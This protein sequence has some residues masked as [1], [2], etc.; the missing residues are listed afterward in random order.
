ML[1]G[2][3]GDEDNFFS[4]STKELIFLEVPGTNCHF[5]LI[6]L[7]QER[8]FIWPT[9][10]YF[11]HPS[12]IIMLT[13]VHFHPF[14]MIMLTGQ[15][16]EQAWLESSDMLFFSCPLCSF[17]RL[18]GVF[19]RSRVTFVTSSEWESIFWIFL[20]STTTSWII[21]WNISN[22]LPGKLAIH[23]DTHPHGPADILF[24][25]FMECIHGYLGCSPPVLEYY[26]ILFRND[27]NYL[28]C[29]PAPHTPKA[30]I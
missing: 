4:K 26:L 5:D 14:S 22:Y 25:I 16:Q 30:R 13:C 20:M 17:I 19:K 18:S 7:N 24:W 8:L 21:F 9:S 6:I 11:F 3:W 2:W 29:L 27:S 23:Q 28:G 12:G 15:M 1:L 10:K